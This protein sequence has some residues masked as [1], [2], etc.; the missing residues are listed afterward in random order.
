MGMYT[1]LVLDARLKS[2]TPEPVLKVLEF[3]VHDGH[4]SKPALPVLPIHPLFQT[5]RWVWMLNGSS[6]YFPLERKAQLFEPFY[7]GWEKPA[8]LMLSVGFSIKNYDDE[9]GKFLDWLAPYVQHGVGFTQ[10]EEEEKLSPFIIE[11]GE[12]Q[13]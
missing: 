1:A 10:Y 2:D 12:I 5:D 6:A 13:W 8:P 7:G 11:E 9:I 4:Y 3:M